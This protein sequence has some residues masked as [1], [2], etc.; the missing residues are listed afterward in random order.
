MPLAFG[1]NWKV[2]PNIRNNLDGWAGKGSGRNVQMGG[3]MGKP[4]SDS[5]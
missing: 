1:R 3:D 2:D 4:M 5:C